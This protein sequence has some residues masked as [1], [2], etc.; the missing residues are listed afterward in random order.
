M[1]K[2]FQIP[3]IH[4]DECGGNLRFNIQFK[5]PSEYSINC[6]SCDYK[7]DLKEESENQIASSKEK[8]KRVS[9]EVSNGIKS[10][11][12][13]IPKDMNELKAA[14]Q[15]PRHPFTAAVLAGL[16]LVAMELSGFGIFVALTWILGNL[17]LNPFSWVLI[18]IIVAIAFAYKDNF[19]KETLST[20]RDD[21]DDIES[22]RDS[23]IINEEEYRRA[24]E[25]LI[26][27]IIN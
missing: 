14:I 2:S 27:D 11:K 16:V 17:I 19:K 18:P 23:G 5:N 20:L 13:S 12:K 25:R 21:F 7:Y 4:C 1:K 6:E 24:R 15:D 8:I 10:A 22:K 3:I 9:K 26:T